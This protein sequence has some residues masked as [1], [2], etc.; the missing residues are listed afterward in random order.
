[1]E[2]QKCS[3]LFCS[4]F[5]F[6]FVI[7]PDGCDCQIAK[8]V[9]SVM[10]EIWQVPNTC[11]SP[12]SPPSPSRWSLHSSPPLPP[13]TS[14][15]LPCLLVVLHLFSSS[16]QFP[17]LLCL[18]SGSAPHLLFCSPLFNFFFNI[19]FP[20]FPILLTWFLLFL[21]L[22]SSFIPVLV[23]HSSPCPVLFFSHFSTSSFS[24]ST[25]LSLLFY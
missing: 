14:S 9:Q 25:P 13:T 17:P 6:H 8:V 18:A 20:S 22:F 1:M 2:G 16:S 23:M 19:T 12:R 3:F 15:H 7:F 4:F 21:L 24:T 5:H 11:R 10:G